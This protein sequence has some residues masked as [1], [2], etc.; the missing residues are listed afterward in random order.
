MYANAAHGMMVAT[1]SGL[2]QG[3]YSLALTFAMTLVTEWLFESLRRSWSNVAIVITA[4]VAIVS[5]VLFTT[6]Y[7]IHVLVGTPEILMTILPG[8]AIGTV[9]T[10]LYV[11]GLVRGTKNA[12]Q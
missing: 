1:R 4:T 6:A 12:N 5:A 8:F 3:S 7:S 2:V 9:Y 10:Y 11:L